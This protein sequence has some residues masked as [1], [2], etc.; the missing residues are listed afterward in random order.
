MTFGNK[1]TTEIYVKQR[2]SQ[3]AEPNRVVMA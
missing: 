2:W 3:A 1:S